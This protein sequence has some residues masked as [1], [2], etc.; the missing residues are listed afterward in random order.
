MRRLLAIFALLGGVCQAQIQIAPQY[1]QEARLAGL[2]GTVVVQG[3]IAPDGS[4]RSLQV[5]RHLGLGLD[6][7]ALE[8]VSRSRFDASSSGPMEW[9]LDFTLPEKQ[10]HWHL[11]SVEFKAPAGVAR[12]A[13]AQ[14]DY[15]V[16]PGI[17]VAAY[18]EAQLLNVIGRA[19]TATLA[20][21]VDERGD[22]G[23]F[24]VLDAS[25]KT[26]GPQAAMLVRTWRFFPGMKA[27]MPVSVPCVV[28][29]VWGPADFTSGAVARQ[30]ER[31]LE[32]ALAVPP[33]YESA[34]AAAILSKTEPEYTA[35]ARQAGVEGSVV[36]RVIVDQE[37]IPENVTMQN[38]ALGSE[39]A[40]TYGGLLNN[41]IVAIKLWRFQP[42]MVNGVAAP[43]SVIVRV[44]FQLAGVESVVL[45]PPRTA[46][47]VPKAVLPTKAQR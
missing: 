25:E 36:F 45:D 8:A 42:P 5:A 6:E 16:G 28:S 22:P 18:D 3:V 11:V 44:N 1:S 39:G 29:L 12:P 30:V 47:A 9:G 40:G 34:S 15:P 32:P 17:G 13:F 26:W 14:A 23:N 46:K 33:P 24:T 4:A 19:A 35:A 21:D 27:G 43:V 10:S 41:A 38:S 2:E 7:Q 31:I 37:G 20:F